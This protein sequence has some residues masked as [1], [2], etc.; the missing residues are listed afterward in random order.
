LTADR[1][2]STAAPITACSRSRGSDTA[3]GRYSGAMLERNK[4]VKS[5]DRCPG[6][7]GTGGGAGGGIRATGGARNAMRARPGEEEINE[8]CERPLQKTH[9]KT[10]VGEVPA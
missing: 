10:C 2:G 4:V 5:G 6:R 1:T 7:A 3:A 8:A 9:L